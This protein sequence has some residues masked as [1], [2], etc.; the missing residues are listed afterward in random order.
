[1]RAYFLPVGAASDR[2]GLCVLR[3]DGNGGPVNHGRR[4]GHARRQASDLQ[5]RRAVL[6]L[7]A[8]ARSLEL[9]EE[10]AR[11]KADLSRMNR[12]LAAH[13]RDEERL[14]RALQRAVPALESAR[15]EPAP[16]ARA[17]QVVQAMLDRMRGDFSHSPA[18]S[19]VAAEFRMNASYLSSAFAREVGMPYKTYLTT[20]RLQRAQELLSD[21]LRRVSEVASEVGY[22]TPDRFRAAFRGWVGL[23]PSKWRDLLCVRRNAPP[24]SSSGNPKN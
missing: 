9:R 21:P 4:S 14:R 3:G 23:S 17:R 2:L 8:L 24:E 22:A 10:S 11:Q 6:L 20:L 15:V 13:G 16:G 18:L 19:Q 5:F 7:R 1:V 12:L